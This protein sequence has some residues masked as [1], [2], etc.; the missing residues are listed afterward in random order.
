MRFQLGEG[1]LDWIEIGRV[2]GQEEEP[3]TTRSERGSSSGRIVDLQIVEDDD[4]PAMQ[5]RS[6]L[7]FDIE[8][9]GRAIHRSLDEPRCGQTAAAQGGNEGLGVPVAEG[10]CAGQPFANRCPTA[11]P[12]EL[13]ARRGLVD[14]DEAMRHGAHDRLSLADPG[15]AQ[16]GDVRALAFAGQQG[17]F[18]S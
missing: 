15:G 18:Y 16:L 6:E 4:V 12:R 13:R 2:S 11:Q 10:N 1:H 14:E 9:E 5:A 17:F 7:R 3:G 8:I